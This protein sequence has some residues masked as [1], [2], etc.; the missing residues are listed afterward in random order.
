MVLHVLLHFLNRHALSRQSQTILVHRIL[1]KGHRLHIR[2]GKGD[3]L[4]VHIKRMLVN[5]HICLAN[6][7]RPNRHGM[8]VNEDLVHDIRKRIHTPILNILVRVLLPLRRPFRGMVNPCIIRGHDIRRVALQ[9]LH[10]PDKASR[11]HPVVPVHH[12]EIPPA[13][14]RH[15][16][17]DGGT[18]PAVFLRNQVERLRVFL[19]VTSG[20][21][22]RAIRRAI[23]H[24]QYLDILQRIPA[25]EGFQ[26]FL[27]VRLHVITWYRNRQDF[28]FL[29]LFH[30]QP[31]SFPNVFILRPPCACKPPRLIPSPI[32]YMATRE[33]S[34]PA[35]TW[36]CFSRPP[37][38]PCC[39]RVPS[40]GRPVP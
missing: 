8:H 15:A 24:D 17:V 6:Q 16:S 35:G 3:E 32:F 21:V 12:L 9:I 23:I 38:P 26:T 33:S 5:R 11:V 28:L 30:A 22:R 40:K 34:L 31:C 7:I 19:L 14:I 18:M 10:Q 20:N 1:E 36:C 2:N 37:P 27:Q 25:D 39:P 29:L 4:H 13:G